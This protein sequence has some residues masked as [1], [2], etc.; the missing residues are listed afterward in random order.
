MKKLQIVNVFSLVI[1]ILSAII[2]LVYNT[3]DIS[4][5]FNSFGL[6]F[7]LGILFSG[8]ILFLSWRLIK[9]NLFLKTSSWISIISVSLFLIMNIL[10]EINCS[11]NPIPLGKPIEFIGCGFNGLGFYITTFLFSWAIFI[12]FILFLI[13]YFKK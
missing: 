6:F 3:L 10:N 9:N 11:L 13:G 7:L 12:S 1:F 4:E 5:L 2:V 8:I